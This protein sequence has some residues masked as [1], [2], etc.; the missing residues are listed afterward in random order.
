MAG[1]PGIPFPFL[2][3]NQGMR[4][5]STSLDLLDKILQAIQSGSPNPNPDP[6]TLDGFG[7]QGWVID[8]AGE[9]H[10]LEISAGPGGTTTFEYYDSPG[11]T[12]TIPA[13]I[14]RPTNKP[15]VNFRTIRIDGLQAIQVAIPWIAPST[16]NPLGQSGI[17]GRRYTITPGF[18][19]FQIV[20]MPNTALGS[21]FTVNGLTYTIAFGDYAGTPLPQRGDPGYMQKIDETYEIIAGEHCYLEITEVR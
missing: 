14:V 3:P 10:W 12:A 1:N 21:S 9:V 13:G 11:G 18:R 15:L 2:F 4:Y 19:Y 5:N 17:D 7:S 20:A 6:V 16:A 8:Q